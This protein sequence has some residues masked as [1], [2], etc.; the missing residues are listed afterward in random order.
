MMEL[1][2][3]YTK[4]S[5]KYFSDP[6]ILNS[7]SGSSSKQDLFEID[8]EKIQLWSKKLKNLYRKPFFNNLV[9]TNELTSSKSFFKFK[10]SS[11]T[12]NKYYATVYNEDVENEIIVDLSSNYRFSVILDI[13]SIKKAT[14]PTV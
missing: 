12:Y 9:D 11:E 10:T 8:F 3:P 4:T 1:V 5:E 2:I 14:P 6:E 13:K 7:F